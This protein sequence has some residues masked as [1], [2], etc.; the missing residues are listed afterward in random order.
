[1]ARL[2]PDHLSIAMLSIHSSPTGKLG[3]KDTGGM[4]VYVRELARELGRRSIQVDIFTRSYNG[5]KDRIVTLFENVRLIHL[6]AGNGGP[7]SKIALYAYLDKFKHALEVFKGNQGIHYDVIHSHYWLSGCLGQWAQERWGRPHMVMFHTLGAIKNNAGVGERE[8]D[9]R[10]ITEK[11]LVQRA[12]RI[13]VPTERESENLIGYYG[14]RPEK[15]GVVPCGVNLKLFRPVDKATARR[16]LGLDH[17]ESLVLYVGR[18]DPVKGLG[19]LLE[20][21]TFL[22][23]HQGLRLFVIGGDGHQ[24]PE[25]KELKSRA[26]KLGIADTVTFAG[27]IEQK[28]LPPYYSAADVLV[29]PS[30][31]ESFGLA[32]LESLACGTPVITTPVGAVDGYVRDGETGR[33]V[34][35][36]TPRS[37]AE[38]IGSIISNAQ[39]P[40]PDAIR[41]SVLDYG[42]H[43]VAS[44]MIAEYEAV[45]KRYGKEGYL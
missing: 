33:V 8:P 18:L 14:A 29:V 10:I 20:A 31:Y 2:R 23:H 45:L 38:S 36:A 32:G 37:L 40:S 1:M 39:V 41:T 28:H 3:E 12:Q 35:P 42:W 7:L 21:M 22:Q 19:R 4:S 27:R 30:Y 25:S 5:R 34:T 44:A 43:R 16:R 17:Q 26:R 11:Q 13:L 15:I 24:D 6:N 9:L